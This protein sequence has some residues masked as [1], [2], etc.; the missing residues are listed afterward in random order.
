MI[1]YSVDEA[2]ITISIS[3]LLLIQQIFRFC[4]NKRNNTTFMSH[5]INFITE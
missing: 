4:D 2:K 3:L 5:V 1:F